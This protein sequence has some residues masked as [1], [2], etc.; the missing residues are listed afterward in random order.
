MRIVNGTIVDPEKKEM[1]VGTITIENDQIVCI[2]RSEKE[3]N[4]GFK[5]F[6]ESRDDDIDA[7]GCLIFPGLIDTHVHF[8][9]PGFTMKEDIL[10]GAEAAAAGGYTQ[11][12]LMANT[13]PHVD[14]IDTLKYVLEK[15]AKTDVKINT[16][17][18]VTLEMKGEKLTDM[19]TL[20]NA[21]A[22]GFTDDGVPIMKEE[23]VL[24]AMKTCA[25][26]GVPVS[27][28]E[29]NP[30]LISE[31]GINRGEASSYY[32]IQGSPANAE[33]SLVKRDINLMKRCV[34]RF[35]VMPTVVIQHI[36]TREGVELV[37][38][39]K[40]NGLDIHA[41]GTPHH[42]TLTEQAV[43]KKG[44]NAKMNPPLRTEEDRKAIVN[45]I[46]DGTIDLIATDHAPHTAEE[47]ARP[48][49]KAPS[50]II[51]LET[52]LSLAYRELVIK[53]YMSPIE[54]AERMSYEPAC[55]YKLEGGRIVEGG[56]ADLTIF[57]PNLSYVVE[58][59]H[60]KASN[61]PFVGEKM[62]GAVVAT[63]CNGRL[64]YSV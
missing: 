39:A 58:S 4:P 36:S 31:N 52:A 38:E 40:K 18:N 46:M 17:A 8:R 41:E 42:F 12:V 10:T 34:E 20:K 61:S 53:G 62:Q 44:S 55:L 13:N 48:I 22:V 45:G 7:S 5:A 27:F 32:G 30:D 9:D 63:I 1:F 43:I 21:G 54:L 15:G 23:L 14:N 33:I 50:G 25:I 49:T 11:V 57:N 2:S 6:D 19:K 3:T 24:E 16:C 51:G 29:E 64:I 35:K 37:R 47:K 56:K 60:S 28:H 26:L 59:F